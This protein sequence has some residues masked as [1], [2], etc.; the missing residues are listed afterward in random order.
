MKNTIYIFLVFVLVFFLNLLLYIYVDWYRE[1]IK[2][3]K[4]WDEVVQP[5]IRLDDS[6]NVNS[7][8]SSKKTQL[9]KDLL[10]DLGLEQGNTEENKSIVTEPEREI[11]SSK[12]VNVLED[13]DTFTS[14]DNIDNTDAQQSVWRL[15]T[16]TST[17]LAILNA[18]SAEEYDVSEEKDRDDLLDIAWE[19]P[20]EYFQ[21]S[22]DNSDL[23]ILSTREYDEVLD[24][25]TVLEYDMPFSL[26]VLDNFWEKSFFINLDRPDNKVR[27]IFEHEKQVYGIKVK[28]GDYAIVKNIINNL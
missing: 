14:I 17:T 11:S 2:S 1:I 12:W 19:Y 3:I 9:E 25:F 5:E 8:E 21:Y 27:F 23:Y 16:I 18:F 15:A 7:I 20:D 4:Y 13:L 6:Y 10:L 28:K 22:N 24:I 26:N